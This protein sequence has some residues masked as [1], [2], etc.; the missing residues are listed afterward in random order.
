MQGTG[1]SMNK[2]F[3]IV[4]LICFRSNTEVYSRPRP[5][6]AL[7]PI[8]WDGEA[9]RRDFHDGR[10]CFLRRQRRAFPRPAW[11]LSR[12]MAKLVFRSSRSEFSV[13]GIPPGVEFF[14][15]H[16]DI[17]VVIRQAFA[18]TAHSHAP[19][20]GH[21]EAIFEIGARP[22]FCTCRRDHPSLAFRRPGKR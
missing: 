12:D 10:K 19:W 7:W 4:R 1:R 20:A 8:S 2:I 5:H 17:I 16:F 11:R 18:E 14:L 3:C 22:N 15:V 13:C 6:C 21:A 9:R